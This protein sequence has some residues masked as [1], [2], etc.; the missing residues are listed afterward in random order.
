MND[1]VAV[2]SSRNH[3]PRFDDQGAIHPVKTNDI[4]EEC[5]RRAREMSECWDDT[6]KEK[7]EDLTD[8]SL[9]CVRVRYCTR[10]ELEVLRF[11]AIGAA[12][13][14][15]LVAINLLVR[16]DLRKS[17]GHR[18]R[19]QEGLCVGAVVI[20]KIDVQR[21]SGRQGTCRPPRDGSMKR[22]LEKRGA[23]RN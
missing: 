14:R 15:V 12:A 21:E 1:Q 20:Q 2:K 18:R 6:D 16:M 4:L 19:R 7:A 17:L 8:T 3:R 23:P 5:R 13:I 9:R 22:A 10:I 11:C